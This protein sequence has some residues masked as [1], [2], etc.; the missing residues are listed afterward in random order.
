MK[1]AAERIQELRANLGL[2]QASLAKLMGVTSVTISR[3]ETGAVQPS[4]LALEKIE[5]TER[6]GL[7][8]LTVDPAKLLSPAVPSQMSPKPELDFGGDPEDLRLVVESE[9]LSFGHQSNPAFAIETSLIDPLPHQRIAVYKHMLPEPRLRFLLADDAG[10]GKTIMSGLYIREMLA[11]RLIRR[12]LVVSPAGLIGNWQIELRNLFNLDFRLVIGADA[13]ADNPFVGS[14]SDR[15]IVSVDTLAGE[16]VFTRLQDPD[17][18]PYDLVIFDE[19]HKLSARRDLDGTFRPTDRYRLG[20]ALAGVRGLEARWRLSWSVHHLLL[21][22]ATPHM[23]KDFP[24][25]CLWRLLEPQILST[26][27]AFTAFPQEERRKRFIRRIKE[28]MVYYN[29]DAIY[30]Q[31]ISDTLSYELSRGE[32]SEWRLYEDTTQYIE[33][34]YNQARILTRSAARFAVGVFQRRLASSTWALLCSLRK[35]LQKLERLIEALRTGELSEDELRRRQLQLDRDVRDPLD[36][37]TGDEE[38]SKDGLEE[39][40]SAE[41]SLLGGVIATSLAQLIVERDRVASLVT[42]AERV[43]DKGEESKFEKLREVLRNPQFIKEKVIIFTEHRDTQD[44]LVRR[45]E[46]LGLTGHIARIHGGMGFK[47]RQEQVEFFRKPHDEDGAQYLICTDAA[48]EGINLQFAWLMINYDIPWNPARLEQRMGRIHRY[49]QERDPVI[50]L[51]LVASSTREGRVMRVVLDKMERVRKELG[52]DKVFDVIGRLFEGVS[53][54]E[55]MERAVIDDTT[56][57]E[58]DGKLT[59]EQVEALEAVQRRIYGDGG[60]VRSQLQE[61]RAVIAAE[62][63]RRLLPGYVMRFIEKTA[64][65]L[66]LKIEGDL[67]REFALVPRTA[68]AAD[69]LLPELDWYEPEARGRLTV[70]RPARERKAIFLRPGEAVFECLRDLVRTKLSVSA[71]RGAV[72]V[73]ANATEP[74]LLH[75]GLVAIVSRGSGASQGP[76]HSE[77]LEERLVAVRQSATGACSVDAVE[78]L[79]L[80]RPEAGSLPS[81]AAPLA[82]F[83]PKYVE[84]ATLY[85]REQVA[86]SMAEEKRGAVAAQAESRREFLTRGF[87]YQEAEL[88]AARSEYSAKARGGDTRSR[89][90]LERIRDRQREIVAQRECAFATLDGEAARVDIGDIELLTNV[91]VVPSSRIEDVK[92]RD[93]AIEAIAV[94]LAMAHEASRGAMAIDV[95]TPAAARAAG[96]VDHPGFDLLSRHPNGEERF[97]EVKGRAQVGEVQVSENEWA[98]AVNHRDK[99]WLYV[100]FHCGSGTPRLHRVK[101]P[102]SE[103]LVKAKGGVGIDPA[104][105][106]RAATPG[107]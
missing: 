21:L 101:D 79:L 93:D 24:Y 10:A 33:H 43:H 28:E 40:E 73:D 50:I 13:R 105:I 102:F 75:V 88:A 19:A 27:S 46:G 26:E 86:R 63:T 76:D 30:P 61:L 39:N 56:L 55:Y 92:H 104:E 107:A 65:R 72:F 23:G 83:A 42:L 4:A 35:R 82:A 77:V 69:R 37:E 1:S 84:S 57:A 103:L 12:V 95:S 78:Q 52:S 14:G 41:D 5:R 17:V 51:N 29:G 7:G 20:E 3:W 68:G 31:R 64:P 60:D 11:R 87:D 58:L 49:G 89:T 85:L 106:L 53:L 74:Y 18:V 45:L 91:I 38:E 90:E 71:Q 67:Q 47:E 9:R 15:V 59:K 6:F 44:F 8:G 81:T 34:Y 100:V 70:Y 97:I 48:G 80:L 36:D 62:E 94:Q 66:G 22:T 99:Y 54:R 32:D 98:K 96:L 25:Y 2:T 16:R